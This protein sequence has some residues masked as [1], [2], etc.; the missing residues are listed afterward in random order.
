MEAILKQD[1]SGV[2]ALQVALVSLRA[3]S[4]WKSPKVWAHGR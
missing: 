4:V 3:K 1:K 2:P